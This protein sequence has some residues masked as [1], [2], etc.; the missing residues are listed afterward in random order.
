MADGDLI[1][2]ADQNIQPDGTD[3][4]DQDQIAN[5]HAV[6]VEEKRQ[7]REHQH[8]CQRRADPGVGKRHHRHVGGVSGL[9]NP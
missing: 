8:T 6:F 5:G 2:I 3:D 4:R 1:G 7:H 9:E